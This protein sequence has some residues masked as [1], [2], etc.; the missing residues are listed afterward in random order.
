LAGADLGEPLGCASRPSVELVA[1]V[2]AGSG[3]D[4]PRASEAP[5]VQ[6]ARAETT[7]TSAI[8]KHLI[9]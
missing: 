8:A 1:L 9:R 6:A 2:V 3:A 4:E 7:Q 5:R